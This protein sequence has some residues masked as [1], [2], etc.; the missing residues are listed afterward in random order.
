MASSAKAQQ[1]ETMTRVTMLVAFLVVGLA[2]C[3]G[4]QKSQP[5]LAGVCDPAAQAT[6][7]KPW[8]DQQSVVAVEKWRGR[9]G[10]QL[11]WRDFGARIYLKPQPGMTEAWLQELVDC[12]DG[13]ADPVTVP[14]TRTL[15]SRSGNGFV[16]RIE[17]E[18][19]TG[20]RE[21]IRRA[22]ALAPQ[23]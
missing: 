12:A 7:E 18:S 1:A 11:T 13:A 2:A 17:A 5:E 16:L 3:A 8:L 23:G 21:V 22:Q 15:V 20:A 14:G 10:K 4:T 19:R 9:E 6:A